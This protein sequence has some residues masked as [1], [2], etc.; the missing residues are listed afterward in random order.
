[1]KSLST[2]LVLVGAGHANLEI[3][4][5]LKRSLY[6]ILLIN[7]ATRHI[8]SG[9]VSSYLSGEVK[10]ED[11][12]INLPD[13]SRLFFEDEILEIKDNKIFSKKQSFEFDKCIVDTGTVS[14]AG[15]GVPLK[16]L[17]VFTSAVS[18]LNQDDI[19]LV[20]GSGLSACEVSMCLA[21]RVSSVWL[22][23]KQESFLA[24][25]SGAIKELI[26]SS[27]L[28]RGVHLTDEPVSDRTVEFNA[29]GLVPDT[30]VISQ[31]N[32]VIHVNSFNGVHGVRTGRM[33]AKHLLGAKYKPIPHDPNALQII[34]C[35]DGTAIAIKRGKGYRSIYAKKYKTFLDTR[36]L[37]RFRK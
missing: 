25:Y 6:N 16:P 17:P 5:A 19:V 26:V 11:C 14:K 32:D 31:V 1:M 7:S 34:D 4:K 3:L 23:V 30:S 28:G 21:N 2:R 8:Y 37:K 13:V 12:T 15:E 33:L 27:L 24:G 22:K 9:R 18:S 20:N 29:T 35:G 10:L 36:Y